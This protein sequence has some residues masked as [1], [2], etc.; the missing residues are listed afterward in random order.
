MG[1]SVKFVS[2][3]NGS[4]LKKKI[5]GHFFIRET[6]P[7]SH[8]VAKNILQMS[9]LQNDLKLLSFFG[10]RPVKRVESS[11][12]YSMNHLDPAQVITGGNN[13]PHASIPKTSL[14]FLHSPGHKLFLNFPSWI[15]P[16]AF[17]I[18]WSLWQR[19]GFHSMQI[20][21]K[22][23]VSEEQGRTMDFAFHLKYSFRSLEW[24]QEHCRGEGACGEGRGQCVSEEQC[25]ADQVL[26]G[27]GAHPSML[28]AA[29]LGQ[30]FTHGVTMSQVTFLHSDMLLTF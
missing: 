30:V 25:R 9:L 5:R 22:C 7:Y 10:W 26:W 19:K 14:N 28:H 15:A 29:P 13:R 20:Q 12:D 2:C 24:N 3:I 1:P 6:F 8:G 16:G 27:A 4:F 18:C 11:R 23:F 21:K 17:W